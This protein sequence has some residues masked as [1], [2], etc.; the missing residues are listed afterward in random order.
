M[1]WALATNRFGVIDLLECGAG[2]S[3]REEEIGAGV[4]ARGIS[5]PVI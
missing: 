4:T 2:G 3:H 1:H 5:A